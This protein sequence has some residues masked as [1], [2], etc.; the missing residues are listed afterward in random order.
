M[1]KDAT[2]LTEQAAAYATNWKTRFVALF[3]WDNF[4]L[5]HFA[6]LDFRNSRPAGSS[7][8]VGHDGHAAW[9]YGTPVQRREDYRKALLG[10]VLEAYKDRNNAKFEIPS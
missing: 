7:T 3:D 6:G 4:F 1:D 8:P 2:C 10:L 9:A 5:W